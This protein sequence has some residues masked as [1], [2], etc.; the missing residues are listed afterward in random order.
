M[1]KSLAETF[2]IDMNQLFNDN[3]EG[4]ENILESK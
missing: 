4:F 3:K 2:E 1:L